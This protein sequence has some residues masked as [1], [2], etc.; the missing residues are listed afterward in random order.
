[1]EVSFSGPLLGSDR[2]RNEASI[3]GSA[4]AAAHYFFFVA[5]AAAGGASTP[6]NMSAT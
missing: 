3:H 6:L 5:A 4:Y 2:R 1:L